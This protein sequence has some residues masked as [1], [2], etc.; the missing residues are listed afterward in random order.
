MFASPKEADNCFRLA[1]FFCSLEYTCP[2]S[3]SKFGISSSSSVSALPKEVSDGK[4]FAAFG[5]AATLDA[6]FCTN[7]R[8]VLEDAK[9]IATASESR[10]C[11]NI[12][13]RQHIKKVLPRLDDFCI[14]CIRLMMSLVKCSVC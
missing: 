13:I 6:K 9:D 12:V 4:L 1:A 3:P 7:R 2:P 8:A 14:R 5:G 10:S 11:L